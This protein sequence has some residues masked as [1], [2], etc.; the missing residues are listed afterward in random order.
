MRKIMLYAILHDLYCVG[1]S[2]M[3]NALIDRGW[4]PFGT[5]YSAPHDGVNYHYQAMVHYEQTFLDGI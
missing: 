5:P 4:Q 3:V 2:E 1:L